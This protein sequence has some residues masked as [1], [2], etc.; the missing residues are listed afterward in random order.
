MFHPLTV[1]FDQMLLGRH[2]ASRRF[3]L[4]SRSM[5]DVFVNEISPTD[6]AD[7]LINSALLLHRKRPASTVLP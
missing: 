4:L 2:A 7:F 5:E 3:R 6:L 1:W